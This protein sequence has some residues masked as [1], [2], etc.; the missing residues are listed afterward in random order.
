M[1]FLLSSYWQYIL[2]VLLC[3]FCYYYKDKSDDLQIEIALRD[4]SIASLTGAIDDQNKAIKDLE[5][6]VKYSPTSSLE[7]IVVEDKSCEAELKAYKKLF[8]E[9]SK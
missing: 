5:V 2:I 8:K 9:M 1:N 7:H 6:K 4:A 3:G